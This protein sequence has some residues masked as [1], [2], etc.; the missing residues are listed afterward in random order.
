MPGA[1][2]AASQSISN[3]VT[4]ADFNITASG[5]IHGIFV[6]SDNTKSGTTGTLWSTAPFAAP[7]SVNN[8]DLLKVTYTLSAS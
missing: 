8:G 6:T 5:T 3:S 2:A 7:L 4:S 1:E